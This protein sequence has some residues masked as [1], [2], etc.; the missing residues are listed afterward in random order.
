MELLLLMIYTSFCWAIF[1]I[2]RIPLNKWS[3]PTAA[4]GGVVMIAAMLLVMNYNH[5]YST[6][7]RD[8]YVT[9]A[10]I[11]NVQ[12]R[13]TEVPVTA[14]VP[15]KQ[16]DVLFR[17]DPAPYRYEVDR[18]EAALAEA[19]S[20]VAQLE[21]QLRAAEAATAQAR[22]DVLASESEFDRQARDALDQAQAAVRQ[23][24]SQY[25]LAKTQEERYRELVS[26]GTVAQVDYDRA[27]RQADSLMAQLNQ[28]QAAERQAAEKVAGGGDKLQSAREQL[29]VTEAQ[30]HEARLAFEAESGGVN[31]Q[32]REITAQLEKARWDLEQTTVRAPTDGMVTQLLLRPGAFAV[33]MPFRP[34]MTFIHTGPGD[35]ATVGAFWQNSLQRIK[36]GDEA[37]V[38]YTAVPGHV[39]KGKVDRVLPVLAQGQ[40]QTSGTL[41]AVESV[42]APGKVPVV[43]DLEEDLTPY[44]LPAGVVG[45]GAIYTEHAHHVALL[46]KI[47]LRMVSW[48][49][50]IFGELH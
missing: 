25:E 24:Q 21:Q 6:M 44:H 8:I 2:F 48:Q 26:K 9:T 16:G 1:K 15:L 3:V 46:R 30:E 12:G 20:N 50:Y 34:V 35:R 37:E 40:T 32:V 27:K 4:L 38:I 45:K 47:L 31:P 42:P 28:A 43:I 14:N 39:F 23:M 41:I 36:P 33:P 11:P 19:S 10:I 5:P 17:I 22:S 7:V 49:N 13:V 29:R 18:L